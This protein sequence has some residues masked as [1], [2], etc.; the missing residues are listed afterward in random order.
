MSATTSQTSQLKADGFATFSNVFDT[1]EI[2]EIETAIEKY[3]QSQSGKLPGLRNIFSHCP[4]IKTLAQS[5]QLI[6]LA[7]EILGEKPVPINATL[8]DKTEESNWYVTWHQDR[9]IVVKD[10]IE[11]PG[12]GPWSIKAKMN[13]VQPPFQIL[14]K[15]V[16]FRIH[17][18]NCPE[19][20]G[21]IKFVKGSHK[22]GFIEPEQINKWREGKEVVLCPAKAGDIIAM[23][24][25]I[26]HASSQV[27]EPT[28]RCVLHIEYS[29]AKLPNG[30]EWLFP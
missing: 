14:E 20:N 22:H 28:N 2:A 25:L 16:A 9:S 17:I 15:V 12:F 21:A 29:N 8:F 24:P 23:H 6:D 11:T 7:I 13:Y 5:V 26:L 19:Q 27:L 1:D 10:K 3:R 18:D 30:L 4:E